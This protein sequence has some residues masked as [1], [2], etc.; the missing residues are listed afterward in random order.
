MGSCLQFFKI[1]ISA[2]V[3]CPVATE[4]QSG[5]EPFYQKT[6]DSFDDD[7]DDVEKAVLPKLTGDAL[8]AQSLLLLSDGLANGSILTQFERLYR[9]NSELAITDAR[10]S[11]NLLKNRYRDISPCEYQSSSSFFHFF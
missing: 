2:L 9:K 5:D 7:D 11:E 8:F 3:G 4:K 6:I 10:T 1:L